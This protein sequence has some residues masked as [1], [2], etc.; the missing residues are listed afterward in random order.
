MGLQMMSMG[1]FM[2]FTSVLFMVRVWKCH[3]DIW[4]CPRDH[5]YATYVC[6][7]A[8]HELQMM[9]MGM[10]VP[11]LSVLLMVGVWKCH[12]DV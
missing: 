7:G 3:H 12:Y 10:F 8:I 6:V 4:F 5:F 9:S 11:F 1:M 2:S